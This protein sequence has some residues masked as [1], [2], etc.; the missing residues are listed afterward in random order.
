MILENREKI[1]E[2]IDK[3]SLALIGIL[4]VLF[5]LIFSSQTTDVFIL[6]KQALIG[7]GSLAVLLLFALR[8]LLNNKV[9][10]RR[11]PFDLPVLIFTL[12]VFLSSVFAVNKADSFISF[13]PFLFIVF[14]YFAIVNTAKTKTGILFVLSAL[15]TGAL[16]SSVF[17]ILFFLKIYPLPIAQTYSQTFTTL[18]S[19]LDQ[20]LYIGF[21][22]P[23]AAYLAFPFILAYTKGRK[24]SNELETA[25]P[26]SD[27]LKLAGFGLS[28]IIILIGLIVT[29]YELMVLQK[30]VFLPL[31]TG[32]QTAF[33]AISQD[34][35]RV[36]QGLLFGAG[37]GNFGV[38]FT[39]FKQAAFNLDPN[40]WSFTFFRSS[41]FVLEL[42]ATTGILGLLSF[43]FLIYKVVRERPIFIPLILII[44]VGFVLP[45]SFSLQA[46][47]FIF[48]ALFVALSGLEEEKENRFFDVEL[49]LVALKKGFLTLTPTEE[50]KSKQG[51]ISKLLPL[52]IFAIIVAACLGLG[53]LST[54]YL[55]SNIRFQQSLIAASKN[56][57]NSTYT[58]QKDALQLFGFSDSY[59]RVFSQT[60]LSLASNLV[61]GT[62]NKTAPNTQT[63][64]TIYALIQQSIN[65]GRQA[66][67]LSPQTAINWQN[68]ATIYR[69]LIG[70][71]QN[72][73]SFA[74]LSA[75][76]AINLD[77]NNP[78]EYINL[79][80][81]YYQ[82]S[83]WD[84][85][86]PLFQQAIN[87]KPDFPNAYY[88]LGHTLI[89]KGDLKGALA[90]FQTVKSL[91]SNDSANLAKINAEIKDLQ[92]QIN[93]P[94]Q[95][96]TKTPQPSSLLPNQGQ[97]VK[98]QGPSVSPI[99]S[100]APSTTPIPTPKPTSTP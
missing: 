58:F 79:G 50:E 36:I 54:R 32:F 57:G 94:T 25:N 59:F 73:D 2:F 77:P 99:P 74:I 38:V 4:L 49:Q 91:V 97:Q 19:L 92:N 83:Q 81:I 60:N 52:F 24:Q 46:L 10:I 72:A 96:P 13:V 6:P 22:L 39:R 28:T 37:F 5:P 31:E 11:N 90:Q 30:P 56:D 44:A 29:I 75:Q 61:A 16:I 80:G 3:L 95:T 82:L 40:L 17:A 8:C 55:L 86:Q 21:V 26:S 93:Q 27:L 69:N 67:T 64:Q 70:F 63:T 66:T 7:T 87:L 35:G 78:N 88:N 14:A 33:A 76:Q 12:A 9:V 51:G 71:G 43:F 18:G 20:A 85:A 65:A 84:K 100:S 41:S 89:Q 98:I 34:S 48:L 62:S 53:F 47:L 1:T 42:L 68:L 45:F 15:I 23:L